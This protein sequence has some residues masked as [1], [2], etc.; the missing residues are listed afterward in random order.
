MK[1]IVKELPADPEIVVLFKISTRQ[2]HYRFVKRRSG[3]PLGVRTSRSEEFIRCPSLKEFDASA[4]T[5]EQFRRAFYTTLRIDKI[6]MRALHHAPLWRCHGDSPSM[7]ADNK[8]SKIR[9][10]LACGL[11]LLQ[12]PPPRLHLRSRE[13]ARLHSLRNRPTDETVVYLIGGHD[14]MRNNRGRLRPA[15][16]QESG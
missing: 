3:Q 2:V 5:P 10:E 9:K 1:K 16:A 15:L 14:H 7:P 8:T 6:V 12:R 13:L 11:C 4:K